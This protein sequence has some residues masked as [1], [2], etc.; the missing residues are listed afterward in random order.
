LT[1]TLNGFGVKVEGDALVVYTSPETFALK[2]H[3]LVQAILSVGQLPP[4]RSRWLAGKSAETEG[5][6]ETK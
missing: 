2:K 4:A 3:N 5:F 1:L 6:Q